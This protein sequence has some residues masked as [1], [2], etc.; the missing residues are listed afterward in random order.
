MGYFRPFRRLGLMS[1]I[2]SKS[3]KVEDSG[4][5]FFVLDRMAPALGSVLILGSIFSVI[6]ISSFSIIAILHK[7]PPPAAAATAAP[8]QQKAA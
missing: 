7:S 1:A 5:T 4:S 6:F 8:A 3:G 2:Y